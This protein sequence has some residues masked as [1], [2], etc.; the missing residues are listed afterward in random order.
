MKK[1]DGFTLPELLIS[2]SILSII[3]LLGYVVLVTSTQSANLTTAQSQLQASLRDTMQALSAEVRMAYS[4]QTVASQNPGEVTLPSLVGTPP[5]AV[6]SGGKSITFRVPT[7][8]LTSAVPTPSQ[9]ITIQLRNEDLGGAAANGKLDPGEDTNGDGM[10]NRRL[11]RTQNG[12]TVPLGAINDLADVEFELLK[13]E[14]T[15]NN[16]LTILRVRLVASKHWG[17]KRQ[18]VNAVLESRLHLEN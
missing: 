17:L 3:S 11:E 10:L 14:D 2:M 6:G 18:L 8:T 9:P 7:A 15:G 5:I 13:S 4:Q 12:V 16:N 1:Q